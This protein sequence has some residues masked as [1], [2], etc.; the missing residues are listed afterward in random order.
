[1]AVPHSWGICSVSHIV[2]ISWWILFHSFLPPYLIN[3]EVIESSSGAL[4][5]FKFQVVTHF[6]YK[7]KVHALFA[8]SVW[9]NAQ[10]PCQF[11]SP[12]SRGYYWG[13][14]SEG[15][16][17]LCIT[18]FDWF[19]DGT[20]HHVFLWT[21]HY[22]KIILFPSSQVKDSNFKCLESGVSYEES[23]IKFN[24]VY[25]LKIKKYS[26]AKVY[27]HR[28]H[29][30][31]NTNVT[32][33]IIIIII[34][35]IIRKQLCQYSA[36]VS[37]CVLNFVTLSTARFLYVTSEMKRDESG[38][39]IIEFDIKSLKDWRLLTNLERDGC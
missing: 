3:S 31:V 37:L 12:L 26:S 28:L 5:F 7:I 2:V 22:R 18:F 39:L 14:K 19:L 27:L 16:Y 35:I 29:R 33:I 30:L 11:I 13:R 36:S 6:Y 4:L 32:L 25:L 9:L 17:Q 21:T 20:H 23:K 10:W 38:F 8:Q 1:M 24:V 34:I 15:S